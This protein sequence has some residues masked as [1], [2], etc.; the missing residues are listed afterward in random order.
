MDNAPSRL[1]AERLDEYGDAIAHQE[2]RDAD[3]TADGT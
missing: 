2:R 1:G 3:E